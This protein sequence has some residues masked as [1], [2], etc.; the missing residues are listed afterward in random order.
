A[1][2]AA[3]CCSTK[4]C[5]RL[6]PIRSSMARVLMRNARTMLRTAFIDLAIDSELSTV[7]T[8]TDIEGSESLMQGRDLV[9]RPLQLRVVPVENATM[10]VEHVRRRGIATAV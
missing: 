9:P 7:V 2:L 6:I 10:I 1:G 8:G 3:S 5:A 4:S